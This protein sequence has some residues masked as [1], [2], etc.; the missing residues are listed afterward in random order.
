MKSRMMSGYVEGHD[1][2]C[3]GGSKMNDGRV[4]GQDGGWVCGGLA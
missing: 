3:V 4:E 1:E 2:G